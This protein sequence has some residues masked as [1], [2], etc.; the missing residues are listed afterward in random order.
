MAKCNKNETIRFCQ[1]TAPE[2][3]DDD[4]VIK[5]NAKSTT[6]ED[7]Y[8]IDSA[9]YKE[10]RFPALQHC[11][12]RQRPSTGNEIDLPDSG[13][14]PD[15]RYDPTNKNVTIPTWPTKNGKTRLEVTNYCNNKIRNS[16]GGTICSRIDV[17][18]FQ[19]YIVQCISDVQVRYSK[20]LQNRSG[21]LC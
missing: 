6:Y 5:C 17:F 3:V 10:Y 16:Q 19:P 1:C 13:P 11:G 2:N 20:N 18:D 15:Y 14:H 7:M 8:R 12:N 4:I 9:G 21:S